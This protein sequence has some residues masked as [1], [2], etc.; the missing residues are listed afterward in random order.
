M[1]IESLHRFT[2]PRYVIHVWRR[3][4]S[5]Y[6]YSVRGVSELEVAAQTYQ[7]LPMIEL[8]KE[9]AQMPDVSKVQIT[10]WSRNGVIVYGE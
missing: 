7:D 3:E 2:T 4:S 8:A 10:D 9:L 1:R 5:D 6:R